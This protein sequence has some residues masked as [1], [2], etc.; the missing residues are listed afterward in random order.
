VCWD[1]VPILQ[2]LANPACGVL[3][4]TS[5]DPRPIHTHDPDANRWP[6]AIRSERRICAEVQVNFAYRWFCNVSI[7]DSIPDHSVFFRAR[8]ERLRESDALRRVFEGVV[9]KCIAGGLVGGEGF[10]SMRA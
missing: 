10:R 4:R 1:R 2:H 7:E 8:H 6:R 3:L 9:A 5:G